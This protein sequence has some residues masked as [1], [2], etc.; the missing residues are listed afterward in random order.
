MTDVEQ[1]FERTIPGNTA[2]PG[3]GQPRLLRDPSF[4]AM[5]CTQFLGAFNDNMFKQVIL[6]ICVDYAT[7]AAARGRGEF[8]NFQGVAQGLFAL[9]FV[10]FSGFAGY[11]SDRYSKRRIVVLCKVAE[12]GIML[13]AVLALKSHA[14][15]AALAVLFL[16]GTH[17]AFFGP[18]KY[19]I[20][21]EILRGRDLPLANGIFLMTT[22]LAVIFG[23]ATA[24]VLKGLLGDRFWTVGA[25][26]MGI[27][28]LGMLTS[29]GV[30]KTPAS[31]AGLPFSLGSLAVNQETSRA[32]LRDRPLLAALALSCVFWFIAGMVPMAVNHYGKRQ[33]Y[34]AF[35]LRDQDQLT[36]LLVACMG[37]GIAGGCGLAG[38]LS[39]RRVNFG[40]VTS[41]A[42]GIIASLLVLSLL[43]RL[44][45][46]IPRPETVDAQLPG[47]VSV[48]VQ[49][50]GARIALTALGGFAG[51]FAV[52]LQVFLQSRPAPDQKGRVIGAMN[53][54]NWI[55]IL[56]S[57]GFYELCSAVLSRLSLAGTW[58]FAITAALMLPVALL[59]HPP[60]A[61]LK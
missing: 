50:W 52:P 5:T 13:L 11:L 56:L 57:A 7:A 20:L 38:K 24:G 30:R 28:A 12:I 40:L 35:E 37:I 42:W 61:E 32:I 36:S 9:A 59:Y 33:L 2:P 22:F 46:E 58:T 21:P 44:S 27:A 51:M 47:W 43:G 53:L 39:G 14:I 41:G 23:T 48:D 25:S 15:V 34:Q 54:L 10:L 17:S 19:G 4:W 55:A 3:P 16:M 26:F 8:T 45:L 31:H 6:L 60:D 49:Q 29:L 1:A 18:A